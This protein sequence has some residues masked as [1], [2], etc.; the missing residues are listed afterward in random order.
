MNTASRLRPFIGVIQKN[1]PVISDFSGVELDVALVREAIRE[2]R[3]TAPLLELV[4]AAQ[5]R[6]LFSESAVK[7]PVSAV[8]AV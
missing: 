7:S 4:C 6:P 2:L 1:W 5:A 8:I 3:K